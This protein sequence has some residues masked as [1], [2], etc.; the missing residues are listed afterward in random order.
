LPFY[1]PPFTSP[2]LKK[3]RRGKILETNP[4]SKV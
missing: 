1:I 3:R 4:I 2:L